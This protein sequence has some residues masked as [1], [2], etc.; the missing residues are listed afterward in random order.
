MGDPSRDQSVPRTS[1]SSPTEYTDDAILGAH[2]EAVGAPI[3]SGHQMPPPPYIGV[4]KVSDGIPSDRVFL[5]ST[6]GGAGTTTV[7]TIAA[8]RGLDAEEIY[9][10]P[11][12]PTDAECHVVLIARTH[13]YGLHCALRASREWGAGLVPWINLLGVLLI[14]DAPG[15]LPAP[16]AAEVAELSAVV[17][18]TWSIGWHPTWRTLSPAETRP[19][20]LRTKHTLGRIKRAI[21]KHNKTKTTTDS[22]PEGDTP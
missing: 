13:S 5:L 9:R 18:V 3:P 7:E 4:S 1:A 6:H 20:D 10:W 22:H 16:L 12:T 19:L 15:K 2:L 21:A 17:P 8:D 11:R 14:A